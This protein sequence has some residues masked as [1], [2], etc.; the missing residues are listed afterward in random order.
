MTGSDNSVSH[1]SYNAAIAMGTEYD[2]GIKLK[3]FFLARF[4]K[5]K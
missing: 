4:L 2:G 5:G 1:G 3:I